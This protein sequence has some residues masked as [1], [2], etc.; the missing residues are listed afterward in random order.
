MIELSEKKKQIIQE[1]GHLLII[2]GPGSGKTFVSILKASHIAKNYLTSTQKVLFL[3]FARPTVSRVIQA[4]QENVQITAGIKSSI[5]V[6]TYHSFFWKVIKTHGHLVGLPR[7]LSILSPPMEAVILSALRS[8]GQSEKEIKTLVNNER[9]RLA[10]E[11]GRVC[12]DL[13]A[14]FAGNILLGSD[15]I[16]R[17]ISGVFPVIILD[18][19]QDTNSDQW[20]LVIQ[21][22][23]YSKLIALADP[24]QRIYD[25]L[26]A[27]PERINNFRQIFTPTEFDIS[28]ENHRNSDTE[29]SMFG[30]DLLTGKFQNDYKGI[31]LKSYRPNQNQAYSALKYEV[32]NAIKRIKALNLKN[33]SLAIL[34]PTKKMMRNVSESLLSGSQTLPSIHNHAMIDMEGVVLS[35]EIIAFLL[36]PAES[37][38]DDAKFIKLINDFFLG[39]SGATPLKKY[40]NESTK[41]IKALEELNNSRRTNNELPKR[42]IINPMLEVYN[43][44]KS[45]NKTGDPYKDWIE[46]RNILDKGICKR[47]FQVA[48]ESRNIRLLD[49]GTQLRDSLSR[50]WRENG[51]YINALKIV[52]QAFIREHFSTTIKPE[53]GVI[54]MNMH[55]AKG[56]QFDEVIIFEGWPHKKNGIII[57]NPD[58]IIPGNKIENAGTNQ[59]YNLRVSVTRAKLQTTIMTPENDIC[60]LFK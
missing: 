11:E 60:V 25:F 4:I 22:G 36:Q 12:F 50:D 30:D 1:D 33:W 27:D 32:L 19:F 43:L 31:I 9:F 42:C 38:Q 29:I 8:S 48:E 54:V 56:K 3:S 59:K 44:C 17:I 28:D 23:M 51:S 46:I 40:I 34:V 15:K 35:A 41:I 10:T 14:Y 49:R 58:R 2:G 5:L 6:D 37:S 57:T 20:R 18:E 26:G 39:R 45:L 55:K 47:L 16:R 52:R 7:K 13:F 24:N 21:L 53:T